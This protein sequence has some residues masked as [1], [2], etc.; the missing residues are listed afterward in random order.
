MYCMKFTAVTT[1]M[2]QPSRCS[3]DRSSYLLAQSNRNPTMDTPTPSHWRHPASRDK[4]SLLDEGLNHIAA[5]TTLHREPD[6][7]NQTA[8]D[9][10]QQDE[11]VMPQI[12]HGHQRSAARLVHPIHVHL[13]SPCLLSPSPL[14]GDSGSPLVC[15][16]VL[17]GLVSWGQG[18]A[19][20]NYPGVY[21]N[22]YE[23]LSWIQTTL[24]ANPW[25]DHAGW[26]QCSPAPSSCLSSP[27][28]SLLLS[29][30]LNPTRKLLKKSPA[31][32]D[33]KWNSE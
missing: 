16:G 15:E 24:D 25:T 28:S 21:V 11:L 29:S 3:M 9:L 12:Q 10:G 22:V 2:G 8:L 4:Y 23:F 27:L 13:P 32:W 31:S 30:H 14:Q 19:E 1:H 33:G 18:C 6:V 7:Y 26:V 17:T 5:S 20:P